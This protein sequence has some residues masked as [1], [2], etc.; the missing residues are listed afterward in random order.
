MKHLPIL[1]EDPSATLSSIGFFSMNDERV[2]L[3]SDSSPMKFCKMI[4]LGGCNFKCPYCKPLAKELFGKKRILSLEQIKANIDW[5][6]EGTPL[7]SIRFSGGECT[8]HPDLVEVIK[9]C[10]EK[11]ITKIAISTNGSAPFSLYEKLVLAGVNDMSISLD[12]HDEDTI[13]KMAGVK[14]IYQ[15][16]VD[17]I[18]NIAKICYVTLGIV[19]T[20][21][22]IESA[23]Q[24]I[25]F[26]Y[27][28]GVHDI[29][30]TTASQSSVRFDVYDRIPQ[31]ILDK[32]PILKYRVQRSKDTGLKV[33]GMKP[34]DS[35]YCGLALDDSVIAGEYH[36]PCA[37]Y[38]REGGSP[39]SKVSC[40][41]RKERKE[42]ADTH[43]TLQDPI[44][45]KYCMDF[46]ID[47]NN[48]FR[49]C[50]QDQ[51]GK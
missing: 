23:L 3:A 48:K 12:G 6:C 11:G 1:N 18:S 19:L 36:F 4:I 29:R 33:R 28:L 27:D 26:A 17:N 49:D 50:H 20:D 30:L 10:K 25:Q 15:K 40:N 14:G 45:S 34:T 47:Y 42:W 13:D 5:W 2:K 21:S 7:E 51:L 22:N 37:V 31:Y 39:I 32:F 44:C 38:M 16:L 41:M 9:Y 8:L 24:T 46:Y 43:N 35:P